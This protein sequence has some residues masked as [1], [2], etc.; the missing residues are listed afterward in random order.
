MPLVNSFQAPVVDTAGA[1]DDDM[2]LATAAGAVTLVSGVGLGFAVGSLALPAPVL[3]VTAL[4][5]GL[6]AAGKWNDIKAH[7]TGDDDAVVITPQS[8]ADALFKKL[9][10][11]G[12]TEADAFKKAYPAAAAKQ[13][14]DAARDAR[15]RAAGINT[16]DASMQEDVVAPILELSRA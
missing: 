14:E 4:G 9:V 15:V 1:I 2:N 13:V 3:G 8:E 10:A 12:M 7:F 11:D 16:A 5:G 6:V